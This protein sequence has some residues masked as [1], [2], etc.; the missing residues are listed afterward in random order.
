MGEHLVHI[1]LL[2]DPAA[3]DDGHAVADLANDRHLVRNDHH[4]DAQ[5][6]IDVLKQ[7]EYRLRGH[8][9]ERAGGLVAQKHLGIGGQRPGNGHALLLAAGQLRR[10]GVRLVG[11][12]DDL[13]QLLDALV[14]L[15]LGHAGD[16]QRIA[17]VARDGLLHQQ[18][19]LL[20]DHAHALAHGAQVLLVHRQNVLSVDE[21]AALGRRVQ[22]VDAA[23]QRGLARA[24]HAD[25]AVNI[26]LAYGQTHVVQR[27][28]GGSAASIYFLEVFYADHGIVR[29]SFHFLNRIE[30]PVLLIAEYYTMLVCYTYEQRGYFCANSAYTAF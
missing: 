7:R 14:G 3:V 6:A 26:A 24:A 9:V 19:E 23:D 21:D 16:L 22:A 30:E 15:G 28:D 2:D 10:I 12:P 18:V 5:P 25:D 29:H 20:K 11:Q 17:D 4:G 8:R 13:Q 1:A 27:R